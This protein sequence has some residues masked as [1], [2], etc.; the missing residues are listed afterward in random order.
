MGH[1]LSRGANRSMAPLIGK[2]SYLVIGHGGLFGIDENYVPVP[3]EDSKMPRGATLLVLDSDKN[4]LD[5][6]PQVRE[7]QFSA[8]GDFAEESRKVDDYW[9][10]HLSP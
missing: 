4:A 9:K 8:N 6:G 2:I 7:N 5:A 1:S 10:A 3:W